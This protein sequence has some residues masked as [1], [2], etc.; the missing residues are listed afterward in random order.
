[1]RGAVVRRSIGLLALATVAATVGC[2]TP[3]PPPPV[4]EPI[5]RTAPL[6]STVYDPSGGRFVSVS[7]D[8]RASGS[9]GAPWRTL[10]HAVAVSPSGSKIVLREG[11]YRE[12]VEI[13]VSKALTVQSFPGETVWMSG[14]APVTGWVA[15]GGAWRKDGWTARFD[16]GGLNATLIDARYPLAGY[17]D[18]AFVDGSPL[19]QV[20]SRAAVGSGSFFV[21]ESARRLWV[22][23]DPAGRTVEGS[24]LVEGL[25]VKG[26]GSV[27]RGVGFK[28]YATNIARHGAVKASGS[29]VVFENDVFSQNAAAGLS[30]T[31]TDVTARRNTFS[32]NGQ[33]GVHVDRASRFTLENDIISNNNIE[34]FFAAAAAGGAKL[35]DSG[36]ATVRGNLVQDNWGHGLWFDLASNNAT[37]VGNITNRN[38]YGAGIMFEY[39]TDALI[40]GN[41]STD[42]VAGVMAGESSDIR[43]WNNTLVNNEMALSVYDGFRAPVPVDIT[44]RNNI[45]STGTTSTRPVVLL[46]DANGRRSWRDMRWSSDSNAYYRRSTATTPYASV[47]TGGSAGKLRFK[48]VPA[49]RDQIAQETNSLTVD[50]TATNPFVPGGAGAGRG[51]PLTPEVAS[52]LGLSVDA[53]AP[54]GAS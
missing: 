49:I 52:A 36:Y 25:N 46:D 34:H 20:A 2:G 22:G 39:S 13:P 21:D 12:S 8:D 6:G 15:D 31:G 53:P 54:M 51:A 18:M 10:G 50:N 7:G 4:I 16:H 41:V 11:T 23:D 33:I 38:R 9:E 42:N 28:H 37:I 5:I 24:V 29:G 30:V 19:V 26:S 44:V 32:W 45:F 43:I 17:P 35:S 1:M 48:N 40:A 47:L 14:S 3:P 27:V